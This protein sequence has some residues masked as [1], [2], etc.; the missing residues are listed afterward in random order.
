MLQWLWKNHSHFDIAHIHLARD[1][2][3]LPAAAHGMVMPTSHPLSKPLDMI[4][5]RRVITRAAMN[6]TLTD[7]E[8]RGVR[9]L[10]E[11]AQISRIINGVTVQPDVHRD[12]LN[13]ERSI[14]ILF[15]ARL[16][17]RKRPI[18]FIRAATELAPRYPHVRFTLIGP[19]EG[20]GDAVRGA[21]LALP[22]EIRQR[23]TWEGS[24]APDCTVQRMA[25]ADIYALPSVDEPFPMSVLEAMSTGLPAVV[26][27]TCGLASSLARA[28]AGIV[29]GNRPAELVRALEHLIERPEERR[30]MGMRA[31]RLA[32]IHYSDRTVAER[33]VSEY[34]RALG[35]AAR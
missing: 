20:E 35:T 10:F 1:L 25:K 6:L 24:L 16:H 2:V 32:R 33:L 23:V 15:L 12:S 11:N 29:I 19:D 7:T 13:P 5:T 22:E 27:T 4:L 18:V 28:R 21:L 34:T 26:T 17:P 30:D 8:E 31:L 9:S 3:T 14:E